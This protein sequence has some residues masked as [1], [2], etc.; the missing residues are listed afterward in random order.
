MPDDIAAL[1]TALLSPTNPYRVL[2]EQLGDL[3]QDIDFAPLYLHHGRAAISPALLALVTIFQFLENV[4]DRQAAELVR[5]RL[6]WKYALHLPLADRG[7]DFSCLSYF[8]RRLLEHGGEQ[9]LFEA[10]LQRIRRLGLIKQRGKQRTDALAVLGAARELSLLELASETLRLALG[11]LEQVAP[12]W[13]Q[14]HLPASFREH[15]VRRIRDYQLTAAQRQAALREVGQD[16]AWLV[17]RLAAAPTGIEALEA[18]QTLRTVWAQRYEGDGDGIRIREQTDSA[19]HL[20]VTPHD[21]GVRAAE[22][23]GHKWRGEKTHVTETAEPARPNF[24]TDVTTANAASGDTDALAT[25]REHL[26]SRDLLPCE[27]YVDSGYISGKQLADSQSAGIALLGPALPDTSPQS[28]KIADFALDGERQQAICPAGQTSVKWRHKTERDGS[29]AVQI[30]FAAATCAACPLKGQCTSG[31]SGRSLH[32]NEYHGLVA[33]RR[34]AAQTASFRHKLW[35]RSAIEATLSELVR[36]H[37][38][39]RHRYRGDAKRHAENLC[40]AAACNLKRLIRVL[41][42]W[43]KRLP[44]AVA[45]RQ[46][47]PVALPIVAGGPLGTSRSPFPAS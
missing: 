22:K 30:Q 23:R 20:I 31:Q 36:V 43:P 14:R 25:V 39:R 16:G 4:P 5:V 33:Q 37:G 13:A 6:D 42:G 34:A 46:P 12:L 27:Q 8:R 1:A 17:E 21:A 19:T 28:L 29:N 2:G 41:V 35:A 32:I 7:F 38:F 26:A 10:V 9:A 15:Y 44:P 45:G 24:I 40:K 18:I 3:F 47:I 11:A